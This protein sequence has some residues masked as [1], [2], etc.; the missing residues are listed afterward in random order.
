MVSQNPE[1]EE[2][3]DQRETLAERCILLL[4][5]LTQIILAAWIAMELPL[6]VLQHGLPLKGPLVSLVTVVLIGKAVYDT[7]FY[8]RY[9]P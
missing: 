2:L 8:D 9:S 4:L 7:F 1:P 3:L 6:P 5:R